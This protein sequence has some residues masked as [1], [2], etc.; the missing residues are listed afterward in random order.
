M[1]RIDSKYD[2]DYLSRVSNGAS[3]GKRN[4]TDSRGQPQTF[5]NPIFSVGNMF[6]SDPAMYPFIRCTKF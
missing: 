3:V 1:T 5:P 4:T 6:E 2:A